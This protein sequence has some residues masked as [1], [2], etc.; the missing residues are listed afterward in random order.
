VANDTIRSFE[1]QMNG[2]PTQNPLF[3]RDTTADRPR[4]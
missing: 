1:H 2:M 3:A 4:R